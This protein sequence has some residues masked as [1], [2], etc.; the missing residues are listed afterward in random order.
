[1]HKYTSIL[2]NYCFHSGYW[3]TSNTTLAESEVAMLELYCE[4]AKIEDGM[5]LIDLGMCIHHQS[6]HSMTFCLINI[7]LL[8][9]CIYIHITTIKNT[10]LRTFINMQGVAGEV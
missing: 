9:I 4:R 1:M 5:H 10:N 3:P 7:N 2:L 8:T 6:Y